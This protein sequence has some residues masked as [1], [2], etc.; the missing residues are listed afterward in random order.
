MLTAVAVVTGCASAPTL[1]SL[2]SGLTSDDLCLILQG[3]VG[4]AV[5]P[6]ITMFPDDELV[7]APVSVIDCTISPADEVIKVSASL[8]EIAR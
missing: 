3:D 4:Q 6:E 1:E 2:P 8:L 7:G 5:L